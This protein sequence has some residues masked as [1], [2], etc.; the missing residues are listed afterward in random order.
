M[1]GERMKV[2]VTTFKYRTASTLILPFSLAKEEA[3]QSLAPILPFSRAIRKG[4]QSLRRLR[5]WRQYS[6]KV[7]T[8]VVLLRRLHK[9]LRN[10][11]SDR[12][13]GRSLKKIQGNAHVISAARVQE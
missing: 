2:R 8:V 11:A 10:V 6:V 4:L 7:L 5:R 13:A 12:P 9:D 3:T 1:K